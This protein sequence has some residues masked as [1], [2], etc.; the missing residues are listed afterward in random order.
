MVERVGGLDVLKAVAQLY[1][2]G[3]AEESDQGSNVV[4]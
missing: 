4:I 3:N 1:D 2:D